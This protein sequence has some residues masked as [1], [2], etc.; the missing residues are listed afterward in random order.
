MPTTTTLPSLPPSSAEG[1][2]SNR[3][4]V[5]PKILAPH[6]LPLL[7]PRR[8][9]SSGPRHGMRDEARI[10]SAAYRPMATGHGVLLRALTHFKCLLLALGASYFI[11]YVLFLMKLQEPRHPFM[12]VVLHGKYSCFGIGTGS[13]SKG[14]TF[15]SIHD[16][17]CP[18]G[19]GPESSVP[20]SS[21]FTAVAHI[22]SIHPAHN[23][24]A[25][26]QRRVH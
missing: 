15:G 24:T 6:W 14:C 2:R 12:N 20:P 18:P 22:P 21:R 1:V 4:R 26:E 25:A 11:C 3:P 8:R 10:L 17:I 9:G 7:A 23:Q 13:L 19:C 16:L 5:P